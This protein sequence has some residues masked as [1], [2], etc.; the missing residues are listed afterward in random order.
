MNIAIFGANSYLAKDLI[1]SFS[2][3]SNATLDLYGRNVG[4]IKQWLN[5]CNP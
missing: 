1:A 2:H 3:K 5:V 4:Q